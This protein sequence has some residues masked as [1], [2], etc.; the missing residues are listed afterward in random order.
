[1]QIVDLQQ[2]LMGLSMTGKNRPQTPAWFEG[3]AR[4][5]LNVHVH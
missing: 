1:V 4:L 2:L 3:A 5:Q